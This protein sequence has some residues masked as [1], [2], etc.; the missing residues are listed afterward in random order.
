MQ[1]T[2]QLTQL[3]ERLRRQIAVLES[4]LNTVDKAIQLLEREHV[5]GAGDQ[6]YQDRRYAKMGL[7]DAC[8]LVIGSEWLAPVQVRDEMLRGGFNIE[9]KKKLLGYCFATLK[10][11]AQKGDL[12]GKQID[13]KLKYRKREPATGVA[14]AA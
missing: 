14:E 7:T 13:G 4:E 12:E 1:A 11:L 3:K 10:R 9:Q 2:Q 6:P 5:A 8:R